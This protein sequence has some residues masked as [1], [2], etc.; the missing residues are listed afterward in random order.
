MF[1][2]AG[3]PNFEQHVINSISKVSKESSITGHRHLV[4]CQNNVKVVPVYDNANIISYV[5]KT[6]HGI[7]DSFIGILGFDGVNWVDKQQ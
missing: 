3:K 4:C 5:T 2:T 6:M 1:F 7:D